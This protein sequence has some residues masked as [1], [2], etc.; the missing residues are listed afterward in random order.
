M[1]LISSSRC[2]VTFCKSR[3]NNQSLFIR[4]LFGMISPTFMLGPN[5]KFFLCQCLARRYSWFG[6]VEFSHVTRRNRFLDRSRARPP[7]GGHCRGF[8]ESA[9][10]VVRRRG[11]GREKKSVLITEVS[12]TPVRRWSTSI[13]SPPLYIRPLPPS[14][15]VAASRWHSCPP[16]LLAVCKRV[17]RWRNA[18]YSTWL[19]SDEMPMAT[20]RL[21][22]TFLRLVYPPWNETRSHFFFFLYFLSERKHVQPSRC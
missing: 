11:G 17:L 19:A 18:G 13:V 9:W 2:D 12:L 4:W 6:D 3:S 14:Y 20:I 8:G 1:D 15:S 10:S 7:H 21:C 5:S 22:E 16:F